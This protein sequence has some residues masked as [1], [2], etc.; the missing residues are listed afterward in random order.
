MRLY[1]FLRA[2][3]FLVM[4]LRTGPSETSELGTDAMDISSL[5][6]AAEAEAEAAEIRFWDGLGF[7]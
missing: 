4:R 5:S 2:R 7:F 6:Q 1:F 3:S